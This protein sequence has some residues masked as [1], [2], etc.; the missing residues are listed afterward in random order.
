LFKN[1]GV[2][3]LAVLLLLVGCRG[4]RP[5]S[6]SPS[7]T[8]ERFFAAVAAEDCAGLQA[9]IGGDLAATVSREGCDHALA[10]YREHGL[11]LIGIRGEVKDGR[12]PSAVLVK[13]TIERDGEERDVQLRVEPEGGRWRIVTM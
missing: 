3:A 4:D 12:D 1:R 5:P 7:E 10:E 9:A 13:I 2:R 6:G 11:R 8:V